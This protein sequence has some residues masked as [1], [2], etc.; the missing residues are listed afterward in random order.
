VLGMLISGD[1]IAELIGRLLV[2]RPGLHSIIA[3]TSG[4]PPPAST[5]SSAP[6]TPARRFDHHDEPSRTT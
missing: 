2:L 4:A 3:E 6:D 1:R 5:P